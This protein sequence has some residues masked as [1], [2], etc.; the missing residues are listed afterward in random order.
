[1]SEIITARLTLNMNK[2]LEIVAK[3]EH[4]DK[5]TV[6]RR[7]LSNAISEWKKEYAIK[8]YAGGKYSTEQA[9][10]F[11]EISLWSFFDLLKEKKISLTYDA[12]EFERDVK[13]TKWK[14]Q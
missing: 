1:M 11:A 2:D 3:T 6:M 4:L 13:N 9:A 10:R 5:S 14:K 12:E 7:L 8:M